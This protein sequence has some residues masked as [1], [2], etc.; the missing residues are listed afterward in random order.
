MATRS[1]GRTSQGG[2]DREYHRGRRVSSSSC[3]SSPSSAWSWPGADGRRSCRSSSARSTSAVSPPPATD[4]PRRPSWPSAA[5]VVRSSTSGSCGR[6]SAS[7]SAG[8]GTTSSA[9]SSTTRGGRCTRPTFSSSRSCGCAAIPSRTTSTGVRTTSPSTI[10]GSCSTTA[11]PGGARR[12]RGDVDTER[13]RTALTSYR[14]LID[15]LLGDDGDRRPVDD[16]GRRRRGPRPPRRG[17]ARRPTG[18]TPDGTEAPPA[19]RTGADARRQTSEPEARPRSTRD[20]PSPRTPHDDT[21]R[22]HRGLGQRLLDAVLGDPAETRPTTPP[23]PAVATT[24]TAPKAAPARSLR[25]RRAGGD[26]SSSSRPARPDRRRDRDAGTPGR[27]RRSDPDPRSTLVEGVGPAGH[28]DRHDAGTTRA[29]PFRRPP[30]RGPG[31]TRRPN[32]AAATPGRAARTQGGPVPRPVRPCRRRPR[33]GHHQ[34]RPGP[35]HRL[36]PAGGRH[37]DGRRRGAGPRARP[38]AAPGAARTTTRPATPGTWTT[39]AAAGPVTTTPRRTPATSTRSAPRR[40]G[41]RPPGRRLRHWAG[42]HRLVVTS[43]GRTS[44]STGMRAPGADR[45]GRPGPRRHA[46]RGR[47]GGGRRGSGCGRRGR[48]RGDRAT[49]TVHDRDRDRAPVQRRRRHG[50]GR[51][52]RHR[53]QHAETAAGRR[54]G[55]RGRRRRVRRS[56]DRERLVPAERADDYG[57]RWDALKGDFVDEPRRAVRQADELV[58]ELLDELQRLFADQ[59][60]NLEQGFDHDR[61]STEDLR[62]ALRRY[63]SFFDRLLSF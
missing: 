49:A 38:T 11:R 19:R 40:T 37:R 28:A 3:S 36:R 57:S 29:A 1:G 23:T 31:R 62:L 10:R 2:E 30:G 41:P 14:S 54:P 34:L 52:H 59:R 56:S 35:G 47:R 50:D 4:A 20:D 61:A 63:R 25:R 33:L 45:A 22:E 24:R 44:T 17:S 8:P 18:P 12:R 60:R 26:Y 39:R 5:S 58:G 16:T 55:R 15:A 48:F 27:V 43:A 21:P 51:R 42:R 7:S 32:D 6:R 13:Q 46:P 9:T 53:P